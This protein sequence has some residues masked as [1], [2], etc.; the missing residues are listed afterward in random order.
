M[1]RGEEVLFL[2]VGMW[3]HTPAGGEM[4][5]PPPLA[6][7]SWAHQGLR[8]AHP[9]QLGCAYPQPHTHAR[10]QAYRLYAEVAATIEE[11]MIAEALLPR[12]EDIPG[13]SFHHAQ[14]SDAR[15]TPVGG[16]PGKRLS[17]FL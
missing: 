15:G 5:M 7:H 13:Q 1:K 10:T 8:V 9:P 3:G 17:Q 4:G 16:L 11:V 12:G 6:C 14:A 2:L